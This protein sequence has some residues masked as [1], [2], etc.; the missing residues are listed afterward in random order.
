MLKGGCL[1]GCSAARARSSTVASG[2]GAASVPET[3]SGS[4]EREEGEETV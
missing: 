3:A 4:N 1:P 2:S